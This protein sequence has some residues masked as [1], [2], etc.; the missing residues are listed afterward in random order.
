[1]CR[2]TK[3][4]IVFIL[5]SNL[6]T[7]EVKNECFLIWTR[8][9]NVAIL[10]RCFL[11]Q[12]DE[13]TNRYKTRNVENTL[14]C[15]VHI[16]KC[17]FLTSCVFRLVSLNASSHLCFRFFI[18]FSLYEELCTQWLSLHS[19]WSLVCLCLTRV[20]NCTEG[21]YDW[22]QRLLAVCLWSQLPANI[23]A[24]S[25]VRVFVSDLCR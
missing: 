15:L 7:Q 20:G 10:S 5:F 13:R 18:L 6:N 9:N 11:R 8:Q 4:R 16:K 23:Q 12:S 22:W 17:S 25:C 14:F 1:M 3:R 2:S 21:Q 19:S 24:V